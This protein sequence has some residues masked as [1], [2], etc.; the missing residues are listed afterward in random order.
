MNDKQVVIELEELPHQP[1]KYKVIRLVNSADYAIGTVLTREVVKE[2][3][4]HK[5]NLKTVIK[6]NRRQKG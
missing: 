3:I 1:E 6:P 4:T 5:S 2:L